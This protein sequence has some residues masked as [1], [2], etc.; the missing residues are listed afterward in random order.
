MPNDIWSISSF[1][2]LITSLFIKVGIPLIIIKKSNLPLFS[3]QIPIFN[4]YNLNISSQIIILLLISCLSNK[5]IT[6]I[7]INLYIIVCLFG[8]TLLNNNNSSFFYPTLGYLF[9]YLP[10]SQVC[11][12]LYSI[13]PKKYNNIIKSCFFGLLYIHTIGIFYLLQFCSNWFEWLTLVIK[14]SVF[15]YL[16]RHIIVTIY[17]I[18]GVCFLQIFFFLNKKIQYVIK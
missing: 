6:L 11:N 14:Y 12:A 8:I 2:L 1:L 18:L 17:A 9:G 4:I 10:A 15:I 5:R 3:G 13:S 7:S 16:P